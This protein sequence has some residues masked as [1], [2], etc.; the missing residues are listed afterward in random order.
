MTNDE[1]QGRIAAQVNRAERE[2]RADFVIDS[3]GTIPE[4]EKQIADLWP[5]IQQ[6]ARGKI[7]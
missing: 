5:K 4:L 7:K 6:S 3:S 2:K 1:A